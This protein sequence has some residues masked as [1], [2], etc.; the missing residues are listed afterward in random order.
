MDTIIRNY[1]VQHKERILK[2]R[3]DKTLRRADEV[4]NLWIAINT[5]T[6]RNRFNRFVTA[7]VATYIPTKEKKETIDIIETIDLKENIVDN[8][9]EFTLNYFWWES[10]T[11]KNNS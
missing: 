6:L 3:E 2:A 4:A 10:L 11:T 7:S 1:F 5:E 8:H 9:K